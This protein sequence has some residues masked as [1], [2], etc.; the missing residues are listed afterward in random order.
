MEVV[1]KRM[2]QVQHIATLW[3]HQN[4]I[5]SIECSQK[6]GILFSAGNDRGV[7]EWSLTDQ[8]FIKVLF[9]VQSSVY[10]LHAPLSAPILA[11]G[12]R[13]GQ[14]NI[15]D[16]ERQKITAVLHQHTLPIFDIKSVPSKNELL[17]CSED[18]TISVWNLNQGGDESSAYQL[19]YHFKVSAGSIRVMA[20]DP[21]GNKVA[22]GGKDTLI[23]IY[24]LSDYSLLYVL[25]GHT[26][27]IASLQFSPDGKYLLSGGRDATLK[28]WNTVDFSLE[29]SMNAHLFALYGIAF[30]PDKPYFATASRDKN[31][32]IWDI[33][34]NLRKIISVDKGYDGHRLSINKICWDPATSN[35]ISAGDDKLVMIWDV[36]FG[37]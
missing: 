32:K 24:S 30:H 26:L 2:I 8:A 35:L 27:P 20:I 14:V 12:E 33:H 17:V 6:P 16:F 25:D 37:N 4:P 18:G 23:R 29:K 31:I 19:L 22:F 11:A 34:F 10:A 15:F 13:N 9:P 21:V 1:H 7:V 28:V 36:Q 5:Y 3:G